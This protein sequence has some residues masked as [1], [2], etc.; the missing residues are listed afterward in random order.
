MSKSG[1]VAQVIGPV[2]DVRFP[3]NSEKLPKILDALVITKAD[4][5][6]VV[7]ECQRHLGEN[8]IRTI[9]MEATDGL[10]R[11]MEVVPTSKPIAMP[12]GDDIRG[13]LFNVVGEPIDGMKA[14]STEDGRSIHRS[15]PRFEDL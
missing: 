13:R 3:D 10:V 7:L 1:V 14:V 9:A 12:T 8:M 11:G 2:V 15:A 6:R 5:T 4:G